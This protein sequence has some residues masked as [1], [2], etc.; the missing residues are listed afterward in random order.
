[1]RGQT[2]LL[3]LPVLLS[4]LF[5][6]GLF[7]GNTNTQTTSY[8]P[9]YVSPEKMEIVRNV[10]VE[11][12]LPFN[13]SDYDEF[14]G[15]MNS[16][17]ETLHSKKVEF[18]S[19]DDEDKCPEG[20][21]K[22]DK[23]TCM[24]LPDSDN[25]S[26]SHSRSQQTNT[27]QNTTSQPPAQT[28]PVG[29][30]SES[31]TSSISLKD[32]FDSMRVVPDTEGAEKLY[33]AMKDLFPEEDS[34][35]ENE[36]GSGTGSLGGGLNIDLGSID[37][38][39]F[40]DRINGLFEGVSGAEDAQEDPD[41]YGSIGQYLFESP[42]NSLLE[43]AFDSLVEDDGSQN[44]GQSGSEENSEPEDTSGSSPL[45]NILGSDAGRSI[46]Q[47]AS[48]VHASGY[49]DIKAE[50]VNEVGV[51]YD[52]NT[53]EANFTLQFDDRAY[54]LLFTLVRP[55]N[56]YI[57][58]NLDGNPEF[59]GVITI[60]YNTNEV[61][62]DYTDLNSN[63]QFS[64]SA[65]M[66]NFGVNF[67]LPEGVQP[68]FMFWYAEGSMDPKVRIPEYL[69][70]VYSCVRLPGEAKCRYRLGFN[71]DYY[72]AITPQSPIT[73]DT[74]VQLEDEDKPHMSWYAYFMYFPDECSSFMS[75]ILERYSQGQL[76]L[77]DVLYTYRNC[78]ARN[79]INTDFVTLDS[80]SGSIDSGVTP[81]VVIYPS[82]AVH[83]SKY[84]FDPKL[85]YGGNI[86]DLYGYVLVGASYDPNSK[87]D[88]S[89]LGYF[90]NYCLASSV[91]G[92][93]S[94]LVPLIS[95][96]PRLRTDL[97]SAISSEFYACLANEGVPNP[98]SK[99]TVK[100]IF[101]SLDL[102]KVDSSYFEDRMIANPLAPY[103]QNTTYMHISRVD[104]FN[105]PGTTY[106]Y[107]VGR[108][109]QVNPYYGKSLL[110][111]DLSISYDG[112]CDLYL[113]VDDVGQFV[114][115]N[116]VED[117]KGPDVSDALLISLPLSLFDKI[118]SYWYESSKS[119]SCQADLD[120]GSYECT[121]GYYFQ[122][123]ATYEYTESHWYGDEDTW[124]AVNYRVELY[125]SSNPK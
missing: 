46:F 110:D 99:V 95:R 77:R 53:G 12:G 68:P 51:I 6:C 75:G 39:D 96:S 48:G 112:G 98:Q 90:V 7:E 44:P 72:V 52:E 47:E 20:Y 123:P 97:A 118:S 27:S 79:N 101:N 88:G 111:D 8:E 86:D 28:S 4:F 102:S 15:E 64:E 5:L 25:K 34:S 37:T 59:R 73:T 125:V 81:S 30:A 124:E 45:D 31:P 9:K 33:D 35:E 104:E 19:M 62:V 10:F 119:I 69:S 91:N 84:Y 3:L 108:V 71:Q 94:Y 87:V 121:A 105:G 17:N 2:Y 49:T 113:N 80:V 29:N 103:Y 18:S 22:V 89:S 11:A 26:S 50:G 117:Y 76:D 36:G 100:T 61:T 70:Y 38:S 106:T 43:D 41:E 114:Y 83:V 1:M 42:E 115:A 78:V 65:L 82:E 23:Y 107:V 60:D 66:Q 74:L 120:Y 85:V 55:L 57:D 116:V 13:E 54:M 21:V 63:R 56:V 16:T 109:E 40:I 32:A 67:P 122:G 92:E 24:K 93:Y 58:T 14:I